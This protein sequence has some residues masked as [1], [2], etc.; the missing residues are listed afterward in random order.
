MEKLSRDRDEEVRARNA[1][2]VAAYTGD[3]RRALRLCERATEVCRERHAAS[4]EAE[5]HRAA[6]SIDMCEGFVR[7]KLSSISGLS[8]FHTFPRGKRCISLPE[9]HTTRDDASFELS[10]IV[11]SVSKATSPTHSL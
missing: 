11:Q 5:T 8:S 4:A 10:Y 6:S 3:V 9:S 2:K 1:G 7:A